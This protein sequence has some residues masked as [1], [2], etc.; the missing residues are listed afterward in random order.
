MDS[1]DSRK[2]STSQEDEIQGATAAAAPKAAPPAVYGWKG[3]T[4]DLSLQSYPALAPYKIRSIA[5]GGGHVLFLTTEGKVFGRGH[6][7]H[8]QLGLG[9]E[10]M[11]HAQAE[12]LLITA[13]ADHEVVAIAGGRSHSAAVTSDGV[14]YCWGDSSEG[15]CGTGSLDK[16]DTPTQVK[17]AIQEGFC[18]HGIPRPETPVAI[19]TISCGA[20]HTLAVSVDDELWAWGCGE[21]LGFEELVHSPMPRRVELLAGRRVLMVACGD[22]HSLALLQKVERVPKGSTSPIRQKNVSKENVITHKHLPSKCA[23]CNKDIYT[24]TD[25]NDTCIIDAHHECQLDDTVSSFETS[26][27]V[28]DDEPPLSASNGATPSG[29]PS[30]EENSET[31]VVS[32]E[33]TTNNSNPDQPG[34]EGGAGE[35]S[36]TPQTDSATVSSDLASAAQGHSNV[37]S[38]NQENIQN[39]E[40]KLTSG[41]N[42]GATATPDV[43][44][45]DS[46]QSSRDE[47]SLSKV[48][49]TD[50]VFEENP[51]PDQGD[52]GGMSEETSVKGLISDSKVKEGSSAEDPGKPSLDQSMSVE[53]DGEVWKR[54]SAS[55][56]K[57]QTPP[58]HFEEKV[59]SMD[60]SMSPPS[61]VNPSRSRSASSGSVSS[62][63]KLKPFVD[64]SQARDYLAR[65]FE[66]E[67]GEDVPDEAKTPSPKKEAAAK[68]TPSSWGSFYP[69]SMMKTVRT[70]TSNALTN[71]QTT[72]DSLVNQPNMELGDMSAAAAAA[73]PITTVPAPA[74]S[75]AMTDSWSLELGLDAPH[76]S[77]SSEGSRSSQSPPSLSSPQSVGS[78]EGRQSLRTLDMMQQNIQRRISA[79]GSKES[80]NENDYPP[81][82]V[83]MDTEVWAWG[84]NNK[85]QLGLGDELS[86]NKPVCIRSLSSRCVLKIVAGANHSLALT[87]NSQ[88]CAWGANA[89]G[90]LGHTE[91]GFS[92]TRIKFMKGCCV[93]DLTAGTN[94]SVF[95]ADSSG[96]KPDIFYCG[97]QPAKDKNTPL[98]KATV[99]ASV[100]E[101]KKVGWVRC[102]EAGGDNCYSMLGTHPPVTMSALYELASSERAFY[103][104]LVKINT[105]LLK[106]LTE[107]SFFKVMDVFPYKSSLH[108][109]VAG[110]LAL[111]KKIGEGVINLTEV[112]REDQKIMSAM[113]LRCYTQFIEEFKR[114]SRFFADFLAI[115]GVEYCAVTG[116]EFFDKYQGRDSPSKSAEDRTEAKMDRSFCRF[117]R[118]M[119]YPFLRLKEYSRLLQKLAESFPLNSEAS[120][121][122]QKAVVSW[123]KLKLTI[124]ADHKLADNTRA[125]WEGANPRLADALRVPSRRVMRDSKSHPVYLPAAGRFSSHLFILFNDM[126]VHLQSNG[127]TIF[128]LETLWIEMPAAESEQLPG[129]VVISPE[130]RIELSVASAGERTEWMMAFNSA[131]NKVLSSLKDVGRRGSAERLNPPLA[132]HASHTFVRNLRCKDGTY[133]GTWLSGKMHGTG[134]IK[135]TDGRKY[136]GMFKHGLQ[137]GHGVFV[138]PKGGSSKETQEGNWKEGKL[139]GTAHIKYANGDEY[140]GYFQ[141]GQ[142]FG[143]GVLQQGRHLSSYASI[144]VGEWLSDKRHGYGVQDDILKGE[145]YMGLWVEDHR[146]GNGIMVTLDGM[147]F[148]G[149]FYVDK[150]TGF[151]LMLT[152]D[153]SCYEGDFQ[154]ITQLSGKGTL[155]LP[156]GD[157]LEGNFHGSWNEGLKV[158]GTFIKC[159]NG[160]QERN[161]HSSHGIQSKYYGKLSV[162]ADKKWEDIFLHC[163]GSLGHDGHGRVINT[164]KA[165]EM[166]AVA[167]SSGKKQIKEM[168]KTS[169]AKAKM[170]AAGLEELETIPPHDVGSSL[171]V[172]SYNALSQYLRKAFDTRFH[173]LG[174]LMESL[175]DV[176]RAAYI[177]VGAHPRLLYHAVQEVNSY[178]RRM[179]QVLRILFPQ[180]PADGGPLHVYPEDYK[181]PPIPTTTED[182][183][184][185]L[186]QHQEQEL[187]G[188]IVTAAGLLYPIL[189]P[190]IY[191]PLFDLYALYTDRDDDRYWERSSKLNRQGD[192]A[193]MA[194]LGIDQKY[195]LMDD[196]LLEDKAQKL[197]STR[198][199]CYAS[200]VD[201]LQQLSTA[202][203]PM[204]KLLV[205][206]ATFNEITQTVQNVLGDEHIWCMDELFPIF[207][208]VVVRAKIR[209]LGAEINM[210]DDLMERHMEHGELGIMFTTLK[211]SYFQIQNEKM[212][213]H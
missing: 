117:Q 116:N 181:H 41:D 46:G 90:Q 14:V 164:S 20:T 97:K 122:L 174:H 98:Q 66:E 59:T 105:N 130:D 137:H 176:F 58:G 205:I 43:F 89:Y 73:E 61:S 187:I 94:H 63:T 53:S 109:M 152:D 49:N 160:A 107:S 100:N 99:P 121:F 158:N 16:L 108:N 69:T 79:G 48:S 175:V 186:E 154:D 199:V 151:G 28:S 82:E 76:K 19:D 51:S 103:Q 77:Q 71:I 207:Q 40:E 163:C 37:S 81:N 170:Q 4:G 27:V 21:Q 126:F 180:L 24:Y 12:P 75:N 182:V 52:V 110:F 200:A 209:H 204:D 172:E 1:T 145:K 191:P 54:M 125:F 141:N 93:W 144:Y 18:E 179:Y 193:L 136:T 192:M 55:E 189:L 169:A 171:T 70:M 35:A 101:L 7:A 38:Q 147:Y 150:L 197:S 47:T 155:T 102:V 106:P 134:E 203:S 29:K 167:V 149:N 62:Q 39:N 183:S 165:W 45:T 68:V 168:Q 85:G 22:S 26:V 3:F 142:R 33:N 185:F 212:P 173:P 202:F 57:S 10:L 177:G 74:A 138:I 190:K 178:V 83:I 17:V 84:A 210:V 78:P 128:K 13:L 133:T 91:N 143:H 156:T 72:M 153:N 159:N 6:N 206:E 32:A 127:H 166:V 8:G 25:T 64:G 188:E 157:Q 56:E 132:R 113:L 88:V 31:S 184:D 80:E 196:I 115:G 131:I 11:G 146:H 123:D 36:S 129:I 208:F 15:Q 96:M 211:A 92:P 119:Q 5:A 60:R 194:F 161:T 201:A 213:H 95:L 112:V 67:K 198:D 44:N 104:E 23:K 148:E 140:K 50:N 139:N 30:L 42:P 34:D 87:A 135:W 65:Q 120:N 195:W 162:S 111:T 86:R 114:Y 2:S 9:K 118:S 124:T